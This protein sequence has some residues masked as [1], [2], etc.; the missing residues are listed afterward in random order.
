V[1]R[2]HGDF[3]PKFWAAAVTSGSTQ[4]GARVQKETK[5]EGEAAARGFYGEVDMQEGVGFREGASINGGEKS[6][7]GE[8]LWLE[9]GDDRRARAVSG[10]RT[11]DGR[12]RRVSE[13]REGEWIPFRVLSGVDHGPIWQLGRIESPRPS[14]FSL[15]FFIFIFCFSYFFYNFCNKASNDIKSTSKT[16]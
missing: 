4:S 8:E 10:W 11:S 3:S 7:A 16:F 12:A 15:F 6:R 14:S 5:R 13:V 1:G 9:E 2:G